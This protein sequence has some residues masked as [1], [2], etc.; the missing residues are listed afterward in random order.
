MRPPGEPS[1][2]AAGAALVEDLVRLDEQLLEASRA[3]RALTDGIDPG[4]P[5]VFIGQVHSG[6]IYNQYPQ[7]CRLEGT[8]RWL[9]RTDRIDV[10]RDFRAVIERVAAE[11]RTT[12]DLE[13]IAIRDAFFLD[14][15]HPFVAAFQAA[16][17]AATGRIAAAGPEAV[18][19]RRQQLLGA[20][21][22]PGDHPRPA[23]AG[24]HT[25]R[26]WVDIDDLV[27]V[28]LLYAATAVAYCSGV[29]QGHRSHPIR[30]AV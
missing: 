13:W 19:R 18:R 8:R 24:A 11:T 3:V 14:P 30:A 7:V 17:R 4:P 28:A 23:C 21:R 5:S 10:E 29:T 15:D 12:A 20:R 2:I 26:E 6:E 16:Y 22:H 25:G 9:P 27:R 1:V